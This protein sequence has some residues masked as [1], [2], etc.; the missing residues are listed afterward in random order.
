MET[1]LVV[2]IFILTLSLLALGIM[3]V[4]KAQLLT[5]AL[6]FVMSVIGDSV[7]IG[8]GIVDYNTHKILSLRIGLAPIEDFFYPLTA[9]IIIPTIWNRL[10]K[11]A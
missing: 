10:G 6:I 1:Y 5:F 9:A 11:H 4:S 8:L 7:I 2:N 3:H